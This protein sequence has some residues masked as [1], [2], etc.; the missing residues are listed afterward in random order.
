M[1]L[2][3]KDL[4]VITKTYK[5]KTVNLQTKDNENNKIKFEG[6]VTVNSL[7]ERRFH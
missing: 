4:P 7:E 1:E 3:Y 6:Y 5:L 2:T